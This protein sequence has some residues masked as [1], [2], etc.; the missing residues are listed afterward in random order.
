MNRILLF[1]IFLS[2]P[3]FAQIGRLWYF[4]NGAGIDFNGGTPVATFDNELYCLDQSAVSTDASG[5]L[6]F[7]SNGVDVYNSNH[8][9]MENGDDIG[10]SYDGGQ[11]AVIVP[12]LY[13]SRFYLFTV[14]N[15]NNANGFRYSVVDM[16]LQG[17]L[18]EVVEKNVLLFAPS[19]E[20]IAY[21]FSPV[22]NCYWVVTHAWGNNQFNAYK[23]TPNGIDVTP[24][25]SAVGS[26]H[27][28]GSPSGYNAVGQFTFSPD[29][30]HA[31]CA[32]YSD[33]KYEYFDFDPFT[34]VMSNAR[35]INGYDKAWGTAFSPDGSKLYTT[36]WFGADVRQFDL[37]LATWTDVV[38]SSSIVGTVS[39]SGQYKAG[40]LELGPDDRIYV[41]KFEQDNIAAINYPDSLGLACDFEDF[42]I[43]LSPVVCNAGLC[44]SSTIG[45]WSI[46]DVRNGSKGCLEGIYNEVIAPDGDG[47]N[48]GIVPISAGTQCVFEITVFN[49][50]GAVVFKGNENWFGCSTE[51]RRL[52]NGVYHYLITSERES[53]TGHSLVIG[54]GN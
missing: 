41:A 31:A 32:I 8:Q 16:A 53:R 22:A 1:F 49:S 10:V 6:L 9:L 18:G 46:T 37:G 35:T 19:T 4:G 5:Q 29:G 45:K 3:S 36:K 2:S 33:G 7:Y 20:R 54:S 52:P 50:L 40:F 39:M 26:V 42:A 34:G 17:G 12:Q 43:D 30:E 48:N 15:W 47:P 23:V 28:G 13:S 44:R 11:C 27:S 14:G 25:V 38:A 51:G 24:V 21:S